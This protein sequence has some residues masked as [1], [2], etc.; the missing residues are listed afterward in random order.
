MSYPQ[1]KAVCF[2]SE[3]AEADLFSA[4]TQ[5]ERRPKTPGLW[6]RFTMTDGD[7]LEGMLSHNLLDWPLSGFLLT[8]P[9][10]GVT[11]QR[12]FLPRAAVITTELLGV[13]GIVA[14]AGVSRKK[15][16]AAVSAAQLKIFDQ[17]G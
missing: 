5:F 15:A 17:T 8:P 3:L 6:A 11:R 1:V 14:A 7:K 16:V 2:A 13:V 9:R 10:T 12:V 4:H